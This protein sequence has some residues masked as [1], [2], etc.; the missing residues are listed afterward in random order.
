MK[1][2]GAPDC[3]IASIR[4]GSRKSP[5]T[6][7]AGAVAGGVGVWVAVGV[8]VRVVWRVAVAVGAAGARS[9]VVADPQAVTKTRA[10][11]KAADPRTVESNRLNVRAF[12]NSQAPRFDR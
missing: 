1:P 7:A 9:S 6:T 12:S 2:Q 5:E 3:R 4:S 8:G 11:Q 10:R